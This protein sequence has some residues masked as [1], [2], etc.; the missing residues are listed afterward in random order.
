MRRVLITGANKGIGL[1][2]SRRCLLDHEDTFVV[3]GSRSVERGKAAIE[4]LVA[5]NSTWR[6]RLVLLEI[7]T[8]SDS[9]VESASKALAAELGSGQGLY[10]ICNNAGIAGG[11]LADIFNTNLLGPRR[12]DSA[13]LPLLDKQV[14]RIVQ[15]S[16]GSASQCVQKCSPARQAFF[17]DAAQP[18]AWESI[19][20]LMSEAEGCGVA[21]FEEH[22][23]GAALGG[24]GLSKAL[25]NCY[26]VH[27][28]A[29]HP[30]L[31][32][33]ACSPGMIQTDIVDQMVP[34]FV[35]SFVTGLLAR[36]MMGAL[37]P[38]RGTVAPMKLLFGEVQGSGHY[39]GS[40]GL[41]S[42]LDR[43]RSPGSPEY[44][45]RAAASL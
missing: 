20:G 28:A 25:L 38:D 11:E 1:A 41:R 32:V 8:S 36:T 24:Y 22:G 16:S 18:Q 12:V 31:T 29:Q 23:L 6:G 37:P 35:P 19:E 4:T 10:A 9:S 43:Y 13:F 33:N 27:L 14:G 40:D 45:G 5:E 17:G 34:W 42:P 39:Y 44:E 30:N 26:T 3:L 2:I 7:D 15:I 21:K